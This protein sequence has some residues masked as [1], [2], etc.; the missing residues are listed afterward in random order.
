MKHIRWQLI[1]ALLGI[2]FL[3]AVLVYLAL[4]STTIERADYGGTYI[5]GIA[6]RPSAI[7]PLFSQ[8]NDVD[9][10]IAALVFSGLTRA[11]ETGVVK[12]DLASGWTSSSDGL[13][14][15]FTL[16]NDV[17][18]H[19]GVEFD[20]DDV[21]YT[22][23][24]IQ[25]PTYKGPPNLS[26]FWRTVAITQVDDL[27]VRF[28]LT[29]PYAPFLSYTTIGILPAHLLQDVPSG[30]LLQNP[31][32]RHPV[33]T[34]PVQVADYTSDS[35]SLDANKNYYGTRAFISRIQFRFY[36]DYESIFAAF[37]RGEVEGISRILPAYLS[38][39]RTTPNLRLY[40]A[41]LGGYSMLLLN[42]TKPALGD[43]AVRQ[44]LLYATDRPHLIKDML[45]GQG[46]V[47]VSPIEPNEWA[48]EPAL[49]Q[50]SYDIEKAKGLLEGAGWKDTNSDGVREKGQDKLAFTLVTTDDPARVAIADEIAKEW[51]PAGVKLTVQPVPASL[52]V[53]NIL[54]P[55]QFDIVL[56]EWRNLSN[57]PDQYE[58]W[59][60]TQI[61]STT[62]LGQNYGGLKDT[63]ISQV[64]ETARRTQDQGK[65]TEL[66]R[67]F[68]ELF[69]D[70][71][72][73]LLL[74]Y[75]VYTYGV[76]AR[77]QG[78]QVAPMLDPSDRFRNVAA[79]YLK[80]K[81]VASSMSPEELPASAS[82][83]PT[84][85]Q[86][87][88]ATIPRSNSTVGS[89]GSAATPAAPPS[90]VPPSVA[91]PTASTP[92]EGGSTASAGTGASTDLPTPAAQCSN[93]SAII[94]TPLMDTAV[95]GLVE[96]R[97]TATRANMTYWKLEYRPDDVQDFA[98]LYRSET[99][100]TDGVL[101]LWS[102][103]TVPNGVYWLQLMVVDNTG[104]FGSPCFIRV[105]VSN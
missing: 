97:G 60:E 37:G 15:T 87:V 81:R 27:T 85:Q 62:N 9:R 100:I 56:Y 48:Y 41:Q 30:D 103:R 84:R 75:P 91:S 77:V 55:R 68:Q 58:N 51:E 54:R 88:V 78:V 3:S 25:D 43:K 69:A 53:Q 46:L 80:T 34:G 11:D 45:Q 33:G 39:A 94:T 22:I 16:R 44:A 50:Y 23:H 20:A 42:L 90:V 72:P 70:R 4:G 95:S 8:Y 26:A 40:N 47:A 66:Y 17:R 64:L 7:N 35:L 28:Q 101:S 65:R 74:Y 63:E 5:E 24:A 61:P 105:N 52:L 98:Q 86:F 76:D 93:Q 102:T 73:A 67:K 92:S 71:V 2:A 89:A 19:D 12:P 31:F 99:P 104:N 49:P 13:V 57:D 32:N 79:W 21:L 1:I 38:K 6:G 10:D 96:I 14:Y 18:W 59:H 82:G 29:Q 36:P 83:A